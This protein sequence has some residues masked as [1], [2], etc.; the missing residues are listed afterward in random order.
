MAYVCGVDCN[1]VR[2]DSQI[3]KKNPVSCIFM[4][5]KKITTEKN[6]ICGTFWTDEVVPEKN[7]FFFFFA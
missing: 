5:R 4:S 7:L 2:N 6:H 3:R 1:L